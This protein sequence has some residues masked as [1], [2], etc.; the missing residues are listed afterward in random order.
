MKIYESFFYH[1]FGPITIG[2]NRLAITDE[3]TSEFGPFQSLIN[4]NTMY[5]HSCHMLCIFHVLVH[6]FHVLIYP[7]L[8]AKKVKGKHK[9]TKLGKNYCVVLYRWLQQQS[10]YVETK[11]EY[12]KLYHLLNEFLNR[13]QTTK[14]LTPECIKAVRLFKIISALERISWAT[15]CVWTFVTVTRHVRHHLRNL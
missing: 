14:D 2:R 15:M 1:L 4:T 9:L 3:D 6:Q 10:I 12:D 7:L 8:P 5:T 13:P 11:A